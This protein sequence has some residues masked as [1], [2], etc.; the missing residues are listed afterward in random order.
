MEDLGDITRLSKHVVRVLGQNPGKFT[1]QGTNTYII[2]TQNPYILI[3]TGEGLPEYTPVLSKALTTL[4]APTIPYL[5]DVSDIIISHWHFDHVGG[6]PSVLALLKELWER[7]NSGTPYVPPRLHKYP[8]G[9]A[10]KGE[11]NSHYFKLPKLIEELSKELY[12]ATPNGDAFHDLQEGQLFK[13]PSGAALLHVLHTPGH[14]VDSICLH[15]PQD[16]A[17]Y[18][19]DTSE[20]DAAFWG[21]GATT[22][23]DSGF[24][25]RQDI[26]LEYV[27]LYPAHGAVVANGRETISTYIKHRLE[28]EDQILGVLNSSIPAE[29]LENGVQAGHWTTWNIVRVIYKAYPENLWIPAA[30]GID[31]HL[32]K[33]EG[34]GFVKRVGGEATETEWKLLVSPPSTPN[35]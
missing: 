30:R 2:G 12:T 22:P 3:D 24:D 20:Q 21:P 14:T 10:L 7:R 16:R 31:L 6:I 32:T 11:H 29:L 5:P 33:L 26:D 28:R 19:A 8:I 34:E 4:S 23:S 27:T 15:V 18:T 17:L 13:E 9:D 35:L 25:T 1:L